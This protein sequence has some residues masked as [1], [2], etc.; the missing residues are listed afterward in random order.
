M[1]LLGLKPK[2]SIKQKS[3]ASFAVVNPNDLGN[4]KRNAELFRL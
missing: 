3:R 1:N 2:V 4:V